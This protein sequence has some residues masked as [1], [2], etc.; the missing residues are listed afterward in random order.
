MEVETRRKQSK[1]IECGVLKEFEKFL[2]NRRAAFTFCMCPICA[3]GILSKKRCA[4]SCS[5]TWVGVRCELLPLWFIA[6][7]FEEIFSI[8]TVF[9]NVAK[10]RP[11]GKNV[12]HKFCG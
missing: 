4:I 1:I 3:Y 12:F 10:C 9:F 6:I 5:G 11:Y 2:E 8:N 7:F